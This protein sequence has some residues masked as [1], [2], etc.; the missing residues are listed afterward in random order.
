VARWRL[1][2]SFLKICNCPAICACDTY[3]A[4]AP[5]GKCESV[6]AMQIEAGQFED[7]VLDRLAWV[8]AIHWPGTFYEGNGA[9][10]LFVDEA[11]TLE[12][13]RALSQIVLGEAGG[14]FFD[15]L[16]AVMT[17]I[18]GPRYLPIQL[19]ID[20]A[21]RR[22]RVVIPDCLEATA[23]PLTVPMTGEEQRAIVRFPGGLAC[24]EIEVAKCRV[25]RSTGAVR[26]AWENTH[27]ALATFEQTDDGLVDDERKEG[28]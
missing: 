19:D 17:T 25:L 28:G 5:Q 13:R 16:R 10:E 27:A 11:A 21:K 15:V 1:S 7:V 20:R 4:P 14:S 18:H 3:R 6:L 12:Q 26:F 2:G 9:M 23:G 8:A 24:R 22:A